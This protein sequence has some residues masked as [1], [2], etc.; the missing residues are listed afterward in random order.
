MSTTSVHGV[1]PRILIN[2]LQLIG[3]NILGAIVSYAGRLLSKL[4]ICVIFGLLFISEYTGPCQN[5]YLHP[6]VPNIILGMQKYLDFQRRKKEMN[7]YN[8]FSFHTIIFS[9]IYAWGSSKIEYKK[10]WFNS[11]SRFNFLLIERKIYFI[12]PETKHFVAQCLLVSGLFFVSIC[13]LI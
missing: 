4:Q 13:L 9:L 7:N 10:Y 12:W 3:M 1:P 6:G 11:S 5:R 2:L 8:V